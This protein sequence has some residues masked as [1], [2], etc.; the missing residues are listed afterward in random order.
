MSELS[1]NQGRGYEYACIQEL[2]KIIKK[3]RPT[4]IVENSSLQAAKKAFD[5]LS[6]EQ[7]EIFKKSAQS[8]IPV[9]LECEPLIAEKESDILKLCIQQD[10]EGEKGDVRDIIILR[11]ELQWEI[12]LSIKHNHFAVK[13]SRISPTIDFAKKWF[14]YSCSKKYWNEINPIFEYLEKEK[15]NNKK[16]YEIK[17]KESKI[18]KPVIEAFIN[19]INRQYEMH[20]NLP[21]KMVEYL[22]SKYDFY[23]VISIDSK[24]ITQIQTYNIHKTLNKPTKNKKPSIIVPFASLPKRIIKIGMVPKKSNTVE[25]YMDNGW[26][27]TFRIHNAETYVTPSLKFD[28]Q[29]KGM[30]TEILTINCIWK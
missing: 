21:A 5:S 6:K 18:Y 16:F 12:G 25:M 8:M 15:K 14:G 2:Y 9:I 20:K 3:I 22:L 30:P 7:K 19:E 28:I 4:M 29:I 10:E 26:Y 13:H 17:N 11:N 24:K 27:F 1:N 23:K